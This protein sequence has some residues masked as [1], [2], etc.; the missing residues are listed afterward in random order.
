[1]AGAITGL[2]IFDSRLYGQTSHVARWAHSVS[3]KFTFH[4]IAKAPVN[5]RPVKSHWYPGYPP[6]SLKANIEGEAQYAGVGR[7]QI[8]LDIGVPYAMH[9]IRGTD[10]PI[11]AES[12]N[13]MTLP[14]NPGFRKRR[15]FTVSGQAP[16]RFLVEA[17]RATARTHSS[18]RGLGDMIF[19]QT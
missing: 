6:G 4:A 3:R 1:M 18:L 14:R 2:V 8:T 16:N 15:H 7:W 11:V 19:R 5:K 12:A 17:A 13:Y 9:V 10:S